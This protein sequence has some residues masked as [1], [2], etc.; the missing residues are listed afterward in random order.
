VTLFKISLLPVWLYIPWIS[1]LGQTHSGALLIRDVRV[2]DCE[3]VLE[4][5]SV[6][7]ENGKIARIGPKNLRAA[8]AEIVDGDGRTLMPGLFDAHV[9]IP[10]SP[11]AALHQFASMGVTTVLDMFGG[12]PKLTAKNRLVSEDPPNMADMR[13]AGFGATAPGSMFAR[14]SRLL[15]PIASPEEAQAWVDARIAE[16]S[17][18]IKVV[19]DERIGGPLSL[20]A[21]RAIIQAAHARGKLA[22]IHALTEQKAREAVSAGADGL[23]HL[24]MGDSAAND[25]GRFAAEHH[26]FVVPTLATL[27]S[28]CGKS[29]G[30]AL[31]ADRRLAAHITAEERK[32]LDRPPDPDQ[33]H[34]CKATA[35]AMHELIEAHVPILAG[36]D[37]AQPGRM[38]AFVM[39]GY[40]ASL[41]VELKLLV[42]EGMTPVEAL[43]AAT[44]A[45][46]RAFRFTDRGLIQPGMRA[47][48]L[49]VEGDPTRDILHT[50]DVVAVWKRGVRIER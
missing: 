48:L 24:F 31:L 10:P 45:P 30:P 5:R 32:T 46:A 50:R 25:F 40:G 33:N 41:H 23:V 43:T 35:E 21:L 2:F 20:E 13:A 47:D 3:R 15:P 14:M 42:D 6:L 4:R 12:G 26:V 36:T 37:S 38:G 11:E 29:P 7:V 17:D 39:T 18:Y 8:N 16:G 22:V 19:Y 27:E 1:A 28:L 44:S 49:L 9:H 34:L